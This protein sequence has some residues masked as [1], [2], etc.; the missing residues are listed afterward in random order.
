MNLA[1]K[2]IIGLAQSDPDY[3]INTKG[4]F[5]QVFNLATENGYRFFDTAANYKNSHLYL[6]SI[7]GLTKTKIISKLSFDDEFNKNFKKKIKL[8]I[9]EILKKNKLKK[10]YGLLI[11]DPLLPLNENKWPIIY[12]ELINFKKKGIIKKIGISVY[13]RFELDQILDVFKPDIVQFP[14]NVF[15]QSFNDKNYLRK[16]K[17]KKN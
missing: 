3:G 4:K 6:R 9:L 14:L 17:K 7:S 15:N 1:N 8:K 11:H 5:K 16:L 10:I 2:F 12:K 13:N